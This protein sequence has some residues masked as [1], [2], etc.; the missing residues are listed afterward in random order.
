MR[1]ERESR[2]ADRGLPEHGRGA[3][4][5]Q[6]GRPPEKTSLAALPGVARS[7]RRSHRL[8]PHRIP[9]VSLPAA[10]PTRSEDTPAGRAFSSAFE[11]ILSG[12]PDPAPGARVLGSEPSPHTRRSGRGHGAGGKGR[13]LCAENAS[14]EAGESQERYGPGKGLKSN[15]F[16]RPGLT[17][18]PAPAAVSTSALAESRGAA[19]SLCEAAG[20]GGGCGRGETGAE[21]PPCPSRAPH[22]VPRAGAAGRNNGGENPPPPLR[23]EG[24]PQGRRPRASLCS[25]PGRDGARRQ[26]VPRRTPS[27]PG[28]EGGRRDGAVEAGLQAPLRPSPM[29]K[30]SSRRLDRTPRLPPGRLPLPWP[31]S[32]PARQSRARR[33]LPPSPSSRCIGSGVERG[34]EPSG[35]AAAARRLTRSPPAAIPPGAGAL[36]PCGAAQAGLPSRAEPPPAP[37]EAS[38]SRRRALGLPH[39]PAPCPPYGGPETGAGGAGPR[40]GRPARNGGGGECLRYRATRAPRTHRSPPHPPP[41]FSSRRRKGKVVDGTK[42]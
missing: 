37:A 2:R 30:P 26:R 18:P 13:C 24:E 25:C 16:P 8:A 20:K 21:P 10:S 9:P 12:E 14:R 35:G 34:A 17:G 6:R 33:S 19:P 38:D 31:P 41:W 29:G 5:Q 28:G 36:N 22:A 4:A 7:R 27:R 3:A 32:P 15:I 1:R 39:P 40:R 11:D 23:E 42:K